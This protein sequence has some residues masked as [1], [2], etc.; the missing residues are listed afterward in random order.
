MEL[1]KAAAG[2]GLFSIGLILYFNK[3]SFS[4]IVWFDV[5]VKE[6]VV[7]LSIMAVMMLA[8]ESETLVNETTLTF[9]ISQMIF[10]TI[11]AQQYGQGE[12]EMASAIFLTTICSF[13]VMTVF[14]LVCGISL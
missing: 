7:P 9:M 10:P 2:G 11:F 12:R 8:G 5:L 4:R 3:P 1:G 14:F 6:V 13:F